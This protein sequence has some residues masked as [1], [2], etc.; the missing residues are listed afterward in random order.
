MRNP[1]PPIRWALPTLL[2]FAMSTPA[3]A[4]VVTEFQRD[5]LWGLSDAR[6]DEIEP[7]RYELLERVYSDSGD[8]SRVLFLSSAEGGLVV[9]ID[10][11]G[12]GSVDRYDT[13]ERTNWGTYLH[14]DGKVGLITRTG[15]LLIP[16]E[17]DHIQDTHVPPRVVARDG[18]YGLIDEHG[19]IALP[20]EYTS[21]DESFSGVRPVEKDGAAGLVEHDGTALLPTMYQEIAPSVTDGDGWYRVKLA[22]R[23]GVVDAGNRQVV[24]AQYD[25]LYGM[26]GGIARFT[27]GSESGFVDNRGRELSP[28]E[29]GG[30]GLVPAPVMPRV[31]NRTGGPEPLDARLE[32]APDAIQIVALPSAI[33]WHLAHSSDDPRRRDIHDFMTVYVVNTTTDVVYL[34]GLDGEIVL[35]QEALDANGQ[36]QPIEFRSP[37]SCGLSAI[38]VTLDA[39]HQRLVRAP[40]YGG[41]D[42]TTKIRF[43]MAY[44]DGVIYSNE[45]A[46]SIDPGQFQRTD[47]GPPPS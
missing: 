31:L 17:Y 39:H 20:V 32:V 34:E 23:W 38:P 10:G 24:P 13:I 45:F 5:G 7:A 2:V 18:L 1:P 3:L 46:G 12:Q 9:R 33:P 30:R 14:R 6:G 15:R 11:D 16:V 35:T 26:V 43:A 41:G 27:R 19:W 47:A 8:G 37:P 28:F 22:D 42:Q 29:H 21:V 25:A 44:G 36:W 4:D 40:R